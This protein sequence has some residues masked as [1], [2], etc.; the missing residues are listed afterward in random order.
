MEWEVVE[1]W[2]RERERERESER[3]REKERESNE[4]SG[5]LTL[6]HLWYIWYRLYKTGWQGALHCP[7]RSIHELWWVNTARETASRK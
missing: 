3:E 5:L 4:T 7:M 2:T 1:L 6:V